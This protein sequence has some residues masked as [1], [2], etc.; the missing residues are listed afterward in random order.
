MNQGRLFAAYLRLTSVRFNLP[1]HPQVLA[2]YVEDF[3][4]IVTG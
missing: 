1:G 3:H 2:K 4:A